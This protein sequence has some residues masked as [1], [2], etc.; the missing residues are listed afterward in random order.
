[1]LENGETSGPESKN[2]EKSRRATNVDRRPLTDLSVNSL[3]ISLATSP[4]GRLRMDTI[5]IRKY[6]QKLLRRREQILTTVSRL[7]EES[8]QLAGQRHL[9]WLDQAGEENEIRLLDRLNDVYLREITRIDWALGRILAG[10]YGL[11]LACHEPIEK[12]RLDTFPETEFCV[13]CQDMRER[14][15]RV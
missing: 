13:G 4:E 10:T 9:D 12:A 15:E 2:C 5:Q 6:Q 7:G 11:C 1:M 8:L 14:V 3:D